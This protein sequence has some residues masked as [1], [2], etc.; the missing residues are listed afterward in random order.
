MPLRHRRRAGALAPPL[1]RLL[2]PPLLVFV[3]ARTASSETQPSHGKTDL[4][5]RLLVE[6]APLLYLH[7]EERWL[8]ADVSDF[9]AHVKVLEPGGLRPV[10]N[11][12]LPAGSRSLNSH[13]VAQLPRDL[14]SENVQP[15]THLRGTSPASGNVPVYVSLTRCDREASGAARPRGALPSFVATYWTFHP[16]SEGKKA[17]GRLRGSHVGDWEHVSIKVQDGALVS[18]YPSAHDFGAYYTYNP[19]TRDFRLTSQNNRGRFPVSPEYAPILKVRGTHPVL[20]VAKGSHGLW[21]DAGVQVFSRLAQLSDVTA[22]GVPW[23]TWRR[24]VLLHR[25]PPQWLQFLGR[26]GNPAGCWHLWRSLCANSGGPTGIPLKVP[27]FQCPTSG[28]GRAPRWG[29][30]LA[31][32]R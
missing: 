6:Y 18:I 23:R 20:Y 14:G 15:P 19:T 27:D 7:P 30:L 29:Q 32:G 28:A 22:P 21:P 13:L 4:V 1:A 16:F 3:L 2:L 17:A 10:I 12:S 25:Q 5:E 8:P 9:I 31:K 24:L 26:W 11:S